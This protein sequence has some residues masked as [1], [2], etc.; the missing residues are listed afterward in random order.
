MAEHNEDVGQL[1]GELTGVLRD[2]KDV[3]RILLGNGRQGL[4][5][6]MMGLETSMEATQSSLDTVSG[7]L[8]RV[9]EKIDLI[10][11]KL[12]DHLKDE[13]LHTARGMFLQKKV[14]AS[15]LGIII[16]INIAIAAVGWQKL[17]EI[18]VL[19]GLL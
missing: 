18:F 8:Q 2:L 10:G 13:N 6:R 17:A 3:H 11:T 4:L 1:K 12:D 15:A 9:S 19:I 5:E 7:Q 16:V 14:L